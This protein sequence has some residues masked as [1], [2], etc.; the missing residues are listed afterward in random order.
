M[1]GFIIIGLCVLGVALILIIVF[2][3]AYYKTVAK[4]LDE[5][6]YDAK[7]SFNDKNFML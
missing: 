3:F 2:A 4:S 5:K 7:E 1:K 6:P